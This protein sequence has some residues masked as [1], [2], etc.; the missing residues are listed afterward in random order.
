LH[1]QC[2]VFQGPF[3]VCGFP[4]LSCVPLSVSHWHT[5]CVVRGNMS[6]PG[7]HMVYPLSFVSADTMKFGSMQPPSW[8][9]ISCHQGKQRFGEYY[10]RHREE[11]E[12][13]SSTSV[14]EYRRLGLGLLCN[15]VVGH[16]MKGVGV[17][18]GVEG[19]AHPSEA[20]GS[21]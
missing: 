10:T 18:Q 17:I 3:W 11:D 5:H 21:T 19:W 2:G 1:S 4:V 13:H 15:N 12:E 14:F 20:W 9:S 7:H 8:Q 6:F 16:R